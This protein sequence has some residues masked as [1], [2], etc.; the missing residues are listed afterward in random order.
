VEAAQELAFQALEARSP[1]ERNQLANRALTFDPDCIDARL[2]ALTSHKADPDNLEQDLRALLAAADVRMASE[3]RELKPGTAWERATMRPYLRAR[4]LL[5]SLLL[6]EEKLTD[7]AAAFETLLSLDAEDALGARYPLLGIYLENENIAAA[8]AVFDRFP[9][10]ES[11]AFCWAKAAYFALRKDTATGRKFLREGME[12]NEFVLDMLIGLEDIPEQVP[13]DY[14]EGSVEEAAFIVLV[15]GGAWLSE[16]T[17]E[18][19]HEEAN[20][21]IEQGYPKLRHERD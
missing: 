12:S 1:S 14:E 18:F 16:T 6:N 8:K 9:T 17:Q 13:R 3:L 20:A 10:E 4:H 15:M 11:P 5:A 21:L 2:I 7:A 19:L